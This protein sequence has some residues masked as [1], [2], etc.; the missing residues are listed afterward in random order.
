MRRPGSLA[1]YA[2]AFGLFA[3]FLAPRVMHVWRLAQR[4]QALG[5]EMAELRKE[6]QRLELELKR[7]R[8][9]PVYIEKVARQKFN[10]AKEGEI[11]YKVVKEGE[12]A[13]GLTAA[14]DS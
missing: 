5:Q 4:S 6:N 9:D 12:A 14:P 1:I 13:Q 3:V 7:L 11:V 8:E 10:K 2:L